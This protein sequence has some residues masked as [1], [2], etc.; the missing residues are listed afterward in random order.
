MT[1]YNFY[2]DYIEVFFNGDVLLDSRTSN[3]QRICDELIYDFSIYKR[4]P[5]SALPSDLIDSFLSTLN[6]A[7]NIDNIDDAALFSILRNIFYVSRRRTFVHF[8]VNFITS[9]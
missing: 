2:S 4:Y 3:M 1:H 9:K 5:I 8:R 6:I 7:R